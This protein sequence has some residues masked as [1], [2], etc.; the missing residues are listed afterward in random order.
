M[1]PDAAPKATVSKSTVATNV[2]RE[3]V[4][5]VHFSRVSEGTDEYIL[6]NVTVP[7]GGEKRKK[8]PDEV[9]L[10]KKRNKPEEV[11]VTPEAAV[12]EPVEHDAEWIEEKT[13]LGWAGEQLDIGVEVGLDFNPYAAVA[14]KATEAEEDE[15]NY[16]EIPDIEA[17]FELGT[18]EKRVGDFINWESVEHSKDKMKKVGK[19]HTTGGKYQK[20][21]DLGGRKYR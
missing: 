18:K 13:P 1:T 6:A 7:S 20:L 15:E 5:N 8:P 17:I 10:P 9:T 21:N 16:Q 2:T 12:G 11:V 19:K 4:H 14:E 3:E